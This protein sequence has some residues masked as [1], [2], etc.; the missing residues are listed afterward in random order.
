VKVVIVGMGDIG[1]QLVEELSRG[2]RNELVLIDRD[3]KRCEQL[4][5]EQD[6]LVLQGDGTDPEILRKAG[7]SEA[8]ALVATTDSDA[9]NTVIAM[10][11]HQLKVDKIIVKLNGVGLRAACQEFGVSKIIAPTITAASEIVATLFGFSR[12][13]FSLVSSGGL[14]LVEL[15]AGT[16]AGKRLSEIDIPEGAQIVAVLRGDQANVPRAREKLEEE[17][18]LIV[19]VE[20]DSVLGKVKKALEA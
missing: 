11:G 5:S 14:R 7:L 19:L 4:A 15:G 20:S 9:I 10:L 16:A 2:G 18:V 13:D 17:D 12:L 3:E 1:K 6:A 8:D